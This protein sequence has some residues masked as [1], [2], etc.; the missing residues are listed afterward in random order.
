[1]RLEGLDTASFLDNTD[2]NREDTQR[3]DVTIGS[4]TDKAYLDTESMIDLLDSH[5]RRRIRLRKDNSRTTVVWNPWH[6]GAAGLRDLGNGEWR[7]FLCVEASN[8]LGAAVNLAPGKEHRMT[9]VLS[10]ETF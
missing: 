8:I 4:Q 9:A 3:G 5:M 10:V 7:Q 1:M 6:E 2:S